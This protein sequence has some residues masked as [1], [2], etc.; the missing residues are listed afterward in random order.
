MSALATSD[1][2]AVKKAR[3]SAAAISTDSR[4]AAM[5]K[6]ASEQTPFDDEEVTTALTSL[7]M[8]LGG[9][10]AADSTTIDWSKLSDLIASR[11]HMTQYTHERL[12]P[13]LA[14]PC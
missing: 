9:T 5:K 4:A 10:E 6:A 12:N 13:G 1:G 14:S 2:R 3:M 7:R 8:L 11:A